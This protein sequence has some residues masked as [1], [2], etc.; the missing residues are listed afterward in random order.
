[1]FELDIRRDFHV[2]HLETEARLGFTKDVGIWSLKQASL[3][4]LSGVLRSLT[5]TFRECLAPCKSCFSMRQ[6][7]FAKIKRPPICSRRRSL[8][9]SLVPSLRG[10]SPPQLR[11]HEDLNLYMIPRPSYSRG[12]R[13]GYQTQDASDCAAPRA[14]L[15]SRVLQELHDNFL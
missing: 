4:C 7:V 5:T 6:S 10:P 12:V 14:Q 2:D 13:S 9:P 8:S 11:P 1:M 15:L 3:G